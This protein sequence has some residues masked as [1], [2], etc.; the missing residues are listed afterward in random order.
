MSYA[1]QRR[2]EKLVN[3]EGLIPSLRDPER[4]SFW[5]IT[6]SVTLKFL[7]CLQ[8]QQHFMYLLLCTNVI[9]FTARYP[10]E[11]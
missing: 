6:T 4:F 9:F 8:K 11:S 7:L 2:L 3:V 10:L 1:D 5:V